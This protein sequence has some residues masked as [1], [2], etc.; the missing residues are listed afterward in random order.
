MSSV[1]KT[2]YDAVSS[3]DISTLKEAANKAANSVRLWS[4]LGLVMGLYMIVSFFVLIIIQWVDIYVLQYGLLHFS[5]ISAIYA[6]AFTF[7][8]AV[9]ATYRKSSV[10]LRILLIFIAFFG[11]LAVIS[12]LVYIVK[13]FITYGTC[14][15]IASGAIVI[16]N[17]TIVDAALG[18]GPHLAMCGD[19]T[20]PRFVITN[21]IIYVWV[22]VEFV[23]IIL[24]M[25]LA[26]IVESGLTA[27]VLE[28]ANNFIRQ[29]RG[30][31]SVTETT[32]Q[33][34]G[35]V[36]EHMLIEHGVSP[37]FAAMS[38]DQLRNLFGLD[39]TKKQ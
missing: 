3:L 7:I 2:L 14:A 36:L 10:F 26:F 4:S 33:E 16:T 12:H 25:Y 34:T 21:I 35:E 17:T 22:I 15:K 13:G 27:M 28:N 9:L 29:A 19:G 18:T 30:N 6:M 8:M 32:K 23:S 37:H 1:H 31:N 39:S 5:L 24:A 20:F 38:N 11:G